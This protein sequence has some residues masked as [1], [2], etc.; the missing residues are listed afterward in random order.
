MTSV[1]NAMAPACEYSELMKCAMQV[2]DSLGGVC[3]YGSARIR[4]THD[5]RPVTNENSAE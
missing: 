2:G 1:A 4:E 5:A 3:C